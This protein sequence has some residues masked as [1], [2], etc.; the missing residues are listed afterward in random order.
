M[1]YDLANRMPGMIYASEWINQDYVG[2]IVNPNQTRWSGTISQNRLW[3]GSGTY[4]SQAG[5]NRI[6]TWRR[7]V[8]TGIQIDINGIISQIGSPRATS[9]L[10]S[11]TQ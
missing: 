8:F 5:I 6:G 1:T 4:L 11:R 3:E 7:G 9:R 10:P 2:L